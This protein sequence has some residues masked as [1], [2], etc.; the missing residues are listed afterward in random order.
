MRPIAALLVLAA[1]VLAGCGAGPRVTQSRHVA[2]YDRIE[3]DSSIDVEFVPGDADTVRVSAGEHVIDH[4]ETAS[5]DGVLHISIRDHG[6]VIGPDP[7]GDTRVQVSRAALRAI[8]VQGSSDLSLG[9]I[10]AKALAIEIT[11]SGSVDAAGSVGALTATIHGSGDAD[12]GRLVARTATVSIQGSGDA[13]VNVRDRLDIS[14][15][16]S[17]DVAYRGNPR[18][19]QNV[20]GS[21]DVHA[22]D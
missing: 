18:V 15:Q 7:Y 12:L 1:L 20:Q 10:D 22:E 8:R 4:V 9:R 16:G 6:I 5:S 2:P 17:G 3:V 13:K 21:G 14:V 11:G 19:S